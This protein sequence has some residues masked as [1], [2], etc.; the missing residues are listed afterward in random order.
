MTGKEL[1]LNRIMNRKTGRTVIVPMD[2]GVSVGPI[3][4][5]ADIGRA[6]ARVGGGGANAVVVHK[7]MASRRRWFGG[8]DIGLIVHLSGSTS[9]SEDPHVKTLVCTVEEAIKLGA[10]AVSVHV[11][12]GNGHEQRMLTDLSA[13]AQIAGEW[14]VPLMAMIYPRGERVRDEFDPS[15]VCHAARLGAEL[16]ADIVKVPY[17]GSA[18]SF[19]AVVEGCQVPVIIAGGPRMDTDR[20]ILEMVRGAVDAGAAGTSIG[21]NVFQHRDP[22]LMVG[23]LCRVVHENAGIEESLLSLEDPAERVA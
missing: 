21:R 8:N 12:V 23:A 22:S 18:E 10:D 3:P 19:R 16:G 1:R 6:V 14:G 13:T 4:G 11:N 7:G 2:H 20:A 17:T 15:A 9:F 5:I